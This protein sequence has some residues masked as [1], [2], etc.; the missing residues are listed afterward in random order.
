MRTHRFSHEQLR[1]PLGTLAVIASVLIER[2]AGG[3][4]VNDLVDAIRERIAD[5]ELLVRLD[6]VVAQTLG[7]EWRAAQEDRFD[8]QLASESIRFLDARTIPSVPAGL[9]PEVSEVHFRV[10]LTNHP[11]DLPDEIRHA[12]G[13][14]GAAITPA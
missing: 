11:L 4:S 13:L 6:A 12:G 9:P 7:S 3:H 10:D 8:T 1:P 2:S 5:P 14:F